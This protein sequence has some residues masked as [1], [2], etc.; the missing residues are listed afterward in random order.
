MYDYTFISLNKELKTNSKLFHTIL[1]ENERYE[2]TVF[3][4]MREEDENE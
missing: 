3:D 1:K 2:T 4:G